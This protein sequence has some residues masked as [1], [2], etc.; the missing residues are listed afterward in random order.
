MK[1]NAIAEADASVAAVVMLTDSCSLICGT[2]GSMTRDVRPAAKLPIAMMGNRY[3]MAWD[4]GAIRR[5][6]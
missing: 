1:A 3:C 2:T 5:N 6:E 4:G